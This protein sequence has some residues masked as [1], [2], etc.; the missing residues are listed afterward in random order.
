MNPLVFSSKRLCSILVPAA[1]TVAAL[2]ASTQIAPDKPVINFRLPA[3]TPE[4]N[5]AWLVRGSQANVVSQDQIDVKELT[6]TLFSGKEDGRVET[7]ILSPAARV[8]PAELVV[9]GDET[10]R[11]INDDYEATGIGWRYSHKDKKVSITKNV[12]VTFRAEFKDILK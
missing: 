11:V 2:A 6:L 12:R 1:A 10:L 7:M 9:T 8:L 4:G 5:R 3:F